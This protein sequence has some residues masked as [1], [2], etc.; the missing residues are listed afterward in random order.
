MKQDSDAILSFINE[1]LNERQGKSALQ[2]NID[3][4]EDGKITGMFVRA[5]EEGKAYRS[6]GLIDYTGPAWVDGS[7]ENPE[8]ILS[9]ED[10]IFVK[11]T[12]IGQLKGIPELLN[13]QKEFEEQLRAIKDFGQQIEDTKIQSDLIKMQIEQYNE[14]S[15]RLQNFESQKSTLQQLFGAQNEMQLHEAEMNSAIAQIQQMSAESAKVVASLHDNKTA[16]V[17]VEQLD[18]I[19]K[20]D[21]IGNDYDARR[22][23]QQAFEEMVR[24]ARK[25]GNHSVSRR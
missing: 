5:R 13:Q 11:E 22:A 14:L 25:A 24:I 17:I 20:V 12:L 3:I 8:A 18:F 10:T 16:D 2:G 21:S 6:G 1:N 15:D 4:A 23:G 9:A 19:M 7:K